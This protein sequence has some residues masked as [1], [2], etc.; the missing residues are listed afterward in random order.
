MH[1]NN[2]KKFYFIDEFDKYH[3]KKIPVNTAIIYRN[4]NH[5][6]KENL[7]K[8]INNFCKSKK[9]EFYLSNN[10]NLAIKYRLNGIY[11][12]SF[13]KSLNAY[14]AKSK[15][16]IILGSAHNIKEL[17]E[18]KKQ[19]VDLIFI[20]PIFKVKKKN[21]WLGVIKFNNL[22]KLNNYNSV[23]LGGINSKNIR[24]IKILN[25][26][27]IGSISYIKKFNESN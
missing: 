4:Y 18:K 2:I 6:Y 25:C 22:S 9:L 26:N 10:I 17:N 14:K 15:G 23:A 3:L 8:K 20:A 19:G 24:K 27:G 12:P 1:L 13:D 5:K 11:V 21:S 16:L 7:I